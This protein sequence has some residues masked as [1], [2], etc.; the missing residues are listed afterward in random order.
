MQERLR[1]IVSVTLMFLLVFGTVNFSA[2]NVNATEVKPE[3][4]VTTGTE[5]NDPVILDSGSCGQNLKW[6]LTDDGVLTISGEGEMTSTPWQEHKSKIKKLV[7][8]EGITTIS[9]YAFR[10]CFAL[11]G[12]L[13]IPETVTAIGAC[14]FWGCSGLTGNLI[15]PDGI[16]VIELL[17]FADCTGFNGTLKLPASLIKIGEQAFS[18]CSS[19]SGNLIIPDSVNCIDRSAFYGCKSFSGDLILPQDLEEIEFG[20]FEG[21]SGFN[22]ELFIPQNVFSIGQEAF[23]ECKNLKGELELPDNLAQIGLCAFA[24]CQGLSGELNIPENVVNIKA[25]AFSACNNIELIS[26]YNKDTI[27]ADSVYTLPQNATICGDS[28]STAKDYADKYSRKFKCFSHDWDSDYTVDNEATCSEVGSKSI[29]C[30]YCELKKDVIV[31]EKT[32]HKEIVASK[33]YEATC[34][35]VGCTD[36]LKC[37]VCGT[38]TQYSESIPKLEHE[39]VTI[40]AIEAT[41]TM[42]G[43]TEGKECKN[44]GLIITAQQAVAA[45]GHTKV[46]VAGYAATCSKEGKTD[47]YKCG[48]CDVL[49]FGS[50]VIP[51]LAHKEVGDKA[52]EATCSKEGKTEGKH[53]SVCGEV[54]VKQEVMPM[55]EHAPDEAVVENEV[56]PTC[57]KDGSYDKVTYCVNC[58]KELNREKIIIEGSALD[59]NFIKYE[60]NG[61]ATCIAYGT[62]TAKCDRC[63]E[64]DT[65][66]D[67]DSRIGHSWNDGVIVLEP[68]TSL[69][70]RRIYTC[71]KCN[72]TTEEVIP[73]I[74]ECNSYHLSYSVKN[75]G[76]AIITDSYGLK[77]NVIIPETIGGYKIT[78]I[79][80]EAFLGLTNVESIH[81]PE[82]IV[83]I[84]NNVF[85]VDYTNYNFKYIS[86]PKSVVSIG[87]NLF[88]D[89]N[90]TFYNPSIIYCYKDSVAHQY[91]IRNSFG[92]ILDIY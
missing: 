20:V 33:G 5:S 37:E 34:T 63:D 51:K 29:H 3:T 60:S 85:D 48:I 39:V 66:S 8:E 86:I 89:K 82:G 43:K 59:H 52:V 41:C 27:I 56:E 71:T 36:T 18:G 64:T 70:G 58:A 14:A 45:K 12:Q 88:G 30:K 73:V 57:I 17:T 38:Y 53:C 44:C 21:C 25:S 67:E 92:Y 68:T 54:T 61:D 55:L 46:L 2:V 80:D 91:A 23:C 47:S 35:S 75:D 77:G 50:D 32:A 9:S 6:E 16:T 22:G 69:E 74:D 79:G 65:M 15:I 62:K 19:L 24:G 78:E 28:I 10:D 4:V 42:L 13:Y 40:P 11:T 84:G 1:K 83:T 87:L 90:A 72:A 81:L 26:F 76:T 31:I 7:M 49:I